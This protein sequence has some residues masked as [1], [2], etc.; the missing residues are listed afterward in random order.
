MSPMTQMTMEMNSITFY[1]AD[2]CKN[3]ISSCFRKRPNILKFK[4][5]LKLCKM[6]KAINKG[7][8]A[9]DYITVLF[10]SPVTAYIC[11]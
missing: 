3:H 2:T 6:I 11:K 10:Y 5:I 9:P 1:N 8:C 4:N 7:V